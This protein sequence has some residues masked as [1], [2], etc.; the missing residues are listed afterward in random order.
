[1]PPPAVTIDDAIAFAPSYIALVSYENPGPPTLSLFA[2]FQLWITGMFSEP[3][4][5]FPPSD[6]PAQNPGQRVVTNWL[7]QHVLARRAIEGPGVGAAG[8]VGTSAVVDA[9]TRALYATKYGVINGNISS[10]QETAV[11]ALFNTVW[12]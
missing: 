8:A 3:T 4:G 6:N 2:Q 9:V 12:A 5:V 1:M 11:I 10:A 7:T